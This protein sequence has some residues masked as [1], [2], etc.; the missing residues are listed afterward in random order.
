MVI[1]TISVNSTGHFFLY[2]SNEN[3]I[4][5]LFTYGKPGCCSGNLL[6]YSL[7]FTIS[8]LLCKPVPI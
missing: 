4:Y 1:Y 7:I 2:D 6:V 3:G 5:M 8:L